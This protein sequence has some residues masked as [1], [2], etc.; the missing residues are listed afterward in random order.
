MRLVLFTLVAWTLGAAGCTATRSEG[1]LGRDA[2]E[3]TAPVAFDDEGT[4]PLLTLPPFEGESVALWVRTEPGTCFALSHL[5]DSRGE[6][7]VD[8]REAGPFCT[9]CRLRT[10][11]AKDEALFVLSRD[12][13]FDPSIGLS[14]QFGLVRC[15]TL[16]PLRAPGDGL[17]VAALPRTTTPEGGTLRVRLR[18]SEHTTLRDPER[19]AALLMALNEELE[20]AGI[21][22]ELDAVEPLE[23]VPAEL[24]FSPTELDALAE[25]RGEAAS[26]PSTVDVVVAGCLRLDDPFFGPATPIDGFTPR[27]GGGAGPADAVFL[28]GR[29]CTSFANEPT[30]LPVGVQ[31]HVLAHELGH[32]LGVFHSVEADGEEDELADTSERNIMHAT[33]GLAIAHGWSASQARRMRAHP[34]V[35]PL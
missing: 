34:W 28:P 6:T 1:P 33:P 23:D 10:A 13:S 4:S 17:Q 19:R 12:E 3:L 21:T 26:D 32:F 31:A 29:R 11:V 15:D 24:T 30:E 18:L 35:R 20:E 2:V 25:L 8:E 16:T 5:E 22:V 14:F 7:W 27:V 9:R